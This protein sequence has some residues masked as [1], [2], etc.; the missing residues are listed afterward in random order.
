MP[1]YGWSSPVGVYTED[2]RGYIV[3]CDAAGRMFFV[4]GATGELLDTIHLG[5][6]VEASPAVYGNMIVVGTRGQRI[7][8]IRIS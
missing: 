7:F 4:R 2:G 1:Y 8:G 5:D 6:N 3:V